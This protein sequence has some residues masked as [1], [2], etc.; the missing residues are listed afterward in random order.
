MGILQVSAKSS[1]SGNYYAD[2]ERELRVW[3]QVI[4]GT[5]GDTVLN[6]LEVVVKRELAKDEKVENA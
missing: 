1:L 3:K 5:L 6:T 4:R 2:A